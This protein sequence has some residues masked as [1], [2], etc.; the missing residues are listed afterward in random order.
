MILPFLFHFCLFVHA[1]RW[2]NGEICDEILRRGGVFV[3]LRK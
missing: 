2:E 3:I 1:I